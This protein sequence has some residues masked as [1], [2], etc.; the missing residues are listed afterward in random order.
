MLEAYPAMRDFPIDAVLYHL[1]VN[2]LPNTSI[3]VFDMD[4]RYRSVN[5]PLPY[6]AGFIHD[7]IIGKT[8]DEVLLPERQPTMLAYYR[9]ALNGQRVT[10]ESQVGEI[11]YASQIMPIRDE[12]GDICAG[13]IVTQPRGEAKHITE[14]V[15]KKQTEHEA[16]YRLLAE[17]STDIVLRLDAH[18][19]CVYVSPSCERVLGYTPDEFLGKSGTEFVHPDDLPILMETRRVASE[20]S[21]ILPAVVMRFRHKQGRAVW[22]EWGGRR[23]PPTAENDP[24]GFVLTL[25]DVTRRQQS[26]EVFRQSEALYRSV[27]TSMSEG[28]VIY[29]HLGHVIGCNPA[30][31]RILGLTQAQM[32]GLS[33]IDPHWQII[34][35][36]GTPLPEESHP[37]MLTLQTDAAYTGVPM[38]VQWPDG[39]L[40]WLS[41][42]AQPL[43][44]NSARAARGVVMTFTDMT[45]HYWAER[46]LLDSELQFRLLLTSSLDGLILTDARGQ[47]RRINPAACAMLGL[48][49]TTPHQNCSTPLPP[50][51]VKAIQELTATSSYRGETTVWRADH[52]SFAMEITIASLEE[53]LTDS[54]FWVLLR[55]I[56]SQKRLQEA[57]V[58]QAR[59]EAAFAK[60]VELDKLK[61]RVMQRLA[62][63]FRTPL[64]LIQL[65]TDAL[66]Q[67]LP[68]LSPEQIAT[69]GEKIADSI[70]HMTEMIEE[71]NLV[72]E[73]G[74]IANSVHFASLNLALL[75]RQIAHELAQQLKLPAKFILEGPET[76]MIKADAKLLR[77]ALF[78]ILRNA[79]RYSE[80][81]APVT[82]RLEQQPKGIALFVIDTGLGILPNELERVFDPF[83]RGSNLGESSGLGL[84][85][86]LAKSAV[87]IHRGKIQ[88]NSVPKQ[89]TT[90][91]IL[92]P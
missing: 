76:V 59:M 92:L 22:L 13:M 28:L 18:Y 57:L 68:R 87:A 51:L 82:L 81:E 44:Q 75:C 7:Q 45:D 42:N 40:R 39:T 67:Y 64:A 48:E 65:Q 52:T 33:P 84:G 37:M 8:P 74:L 41:A 34:Q 38:G 50:F 88:I 70:Q 35:E 16:Q 83:F 30:A 19:R 27:I 26:E 77:R 69:K 73:G 5:G 46:A 89:G 20:G 9:A 63:E 62:H 10:V 54:P 12:Q 91:Q 47:I 53:G 2:N 14:Q 66:L 90:V 79:A 32:M 23:L 4:L 25:R 71:I 17:N 58:E 31:E 80:P 55:D 15:E 61:L 6:A 86:T 85:L 56:S 3:I 21:S 36:D 72:L 49:E 24:A 60:E 29:N 1:L 11:G 78:H 43:L